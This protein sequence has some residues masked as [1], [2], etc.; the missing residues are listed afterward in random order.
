MSDDHE[1]AR[2]LAEA[3]LEAFAKG[4]DKRGDDLAAQ[5]A[6]LDRSAVEEVVQD[7]DDDAASNHD[8]PE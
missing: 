4:E 3:A 5:A 8:V 6:E 1:K 2:S 7:L